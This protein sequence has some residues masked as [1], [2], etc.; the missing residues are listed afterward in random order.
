[1]TRSI[2]L[3]VPL[4]LRPLNLIEAACRRS[5]PLLS[6]LPFD[7]RDAKFRAIIGNRTVKNS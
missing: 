2:R 7:E 6:K 4:L 1:M 5:L 3:S